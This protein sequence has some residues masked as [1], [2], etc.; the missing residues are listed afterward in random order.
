MRQA[1]VSQFI[2]IVYRTFIL[3]RVRNTQKQANRTVV[4]KREI[5]FADYRFVSEMYECPAAALIELGR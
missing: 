1:I 3:L 4:V 5:F 2:C